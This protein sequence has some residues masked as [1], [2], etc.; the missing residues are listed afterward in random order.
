MNGGLI[1]K[2][3]MELVIVH[4]TLQGVDTNDGLA[5]EVVNPG[6]TVLR[7]HSCLGLLLSLT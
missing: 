1:P 5:T 7:I 6:S 3:I 2:L 4:E